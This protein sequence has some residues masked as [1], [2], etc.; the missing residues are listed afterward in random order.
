MTEHRFKI[1][2]KI[3]QSDTMS[4]EEA[5]NFVTLQIIQITSRHEIVLYCAE[6]TIEEKDL[7]WKEKYKER[8]VYHQ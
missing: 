5:V 4:Y 6:Q 7:R 3:L 8:S 2:L 1:Q